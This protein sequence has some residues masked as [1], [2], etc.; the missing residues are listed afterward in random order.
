MVKLNS[1]GGSAQGRGI[2]QA[3]AAKAKAQTQ[4]LE[5]TQQGNLLK[6]KSADQVSLNN[7]YLG[8]QKEAK[9]LKEAKGTAPA[10][11]VEETT[12][13]PDTQTE[14]TPA[15]ENDANTGKGQGASRG[16]GKGS[17][18]IP[19]GL[20]KKSSVDLP[21]GNPWK[22]VLEQ[23]E[24]D[25]ARAVEKQKAAEEKKRADAEKA[26][27]EEQK[28]KEEDAKL[29]ADLMSLMQKMLLTMDQLHKSV[30]LTAGK[31]ANTEVKVDEI[32][33]AAPTV[34]V[35]EAAPAEPKS[36]VLPPADTPVPTIH[37]AVTT[38][39]LDDPIKLQQEIQAFKHQQ[40]G[41]DDAMVEFLNTRFPETKFTLEG[42]DLKYTLDGKNFLVATSGESF[43]RLA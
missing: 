35:E 13:Y 25:E 41:S 15:T 12:T 32:Q 23:R 29:M 24:A 10:D 33:P 22:A 21:D 38:G 18:R 39:P 3:G 26:A 9:E 27:E 42:T 4:T 16:K 14:D 20:A 31:P 43:P 34:P 5:H 37:E 8:I 19:P 28:T 30:A 1:I 11:E 7:D 17:G 2:E 36:E 6:G 40:A